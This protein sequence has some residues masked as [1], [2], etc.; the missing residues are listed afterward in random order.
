MKFDFP[1]ASLKLACLN[2]SWE[3][4]YKIEATV[5]SEYFEDKVQTKRYNHHCLSTLKYR[6]C[7]EISSSYRWETLTSRHDLV[8]SKPSPYEVGGRAVIAAFVCAGLRHQ[9][10]VCGW[11]IKSRV[12]FQLF[13]CRALTQLLTCSSSWRWENLIPGWTGFIHFKMKENDLW[14][15]ELRNAGREIDE[16]EWDNL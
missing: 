7:E 6:A 4:P 8:W 1:G 3:N 2:S 14:L 10:G 16:D 12:C 13:L 15:M 5:P 9:T 11:D